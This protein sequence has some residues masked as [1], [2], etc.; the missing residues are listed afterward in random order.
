MTRFMPLVVVLFAT[1]CRAEMPKLFREGAFT[2]ATL[3]EAADHY[4]ALGEEVAIKELE[5]LIVDWLTDFKGDFSRNERIGWVCRILFQPKGKTPL[6]PPGFGGHRL[7]WNSMPLTR[8]PL[9]PV[10]VSGK[11]FFVLS[12]GYN[13]GGSPEDP[14]HYL[15]YCRTN[16][17]FRTERVPKPS[18]L[19]ALKDL[20]KLHRSE[21]WKAIKW[22]DSGQGF[23]YAFREDSAW[24]FIKAQAEKMPA[25]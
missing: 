2:C 18:R 6:R 21:G 10:A 16:G 4:V 13:L 23:S 7:P 20:G 3:A 12:E 8:W 25:K 22:E 19:Q 17:R 24:S 5:S 15:K 1:P 9:Y 14:R 11:S